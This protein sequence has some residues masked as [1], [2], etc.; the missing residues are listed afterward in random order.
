MQNVTVTLPEEVARWTRIWAARHNT[1]VSRLLGG[2]LE[3]LMEREEGYE[4]SKKAYLKR[5][6]KKLSGGVPYPDRGDLH[7]RPR[8]R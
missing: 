4:A 5:K 3:D 8:L 2:M 1:S 6:P 7:D